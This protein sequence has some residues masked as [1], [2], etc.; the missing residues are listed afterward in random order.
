L[1]GVRETTLCDK[2]CQCL[3]TGRSFSLVS[4]TNKTDRHYIA[5][6]LLKG[7][8]NAITIIRYWI[9]RPITNSVH[10][11]IGPYN[12]GSLPT[13]STIL[14]NLSCRTFVYKRLATIPAT[15]VVIKLN[16]II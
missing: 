3:A 6:I 13:R 16:V 2:V 4:F 14:Y 5:E 10:Y 12:L 11:K 7:T 8:L 15:T 1:G 9:T